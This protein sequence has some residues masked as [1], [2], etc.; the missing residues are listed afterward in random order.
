M[1]VPGLA[2]GIAVWVLAPQGAIAKECVEPYGYVV[3][4]SR[5]ETEVRLKPE[6]AELAAKPAASYEVIENSYSVVSPRDT[7]ETMPRLGASEIGRPVR[8]ARKAAASKAGS[9]ERKARR[10]SDRRPSRAKPTM[11]LGVIEPSVAKADADEKACVGAMGRLV[12]DASGSYVVEIREEC[13]A[14]TTAAK[15]DSEVKPARSLPAF[16][17]DDALSDDG[18]IYEEE[19]SPRRTRGSASGRAKVSDRRPPTPA[20]RRSSPEQ[21]LLIKA[22]YN[23]S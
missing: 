20:R 1:R 8:G 19:L 7:A 17:D 23:R 10:R 15:G 21:A 5:Y 12:K 22:G 2:V 9:D 16:F 13:K 4:I 3:E 18:M 6:C 14:L 11:S